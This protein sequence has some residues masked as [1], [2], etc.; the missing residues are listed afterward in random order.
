VSCALDIDQDLSLRTGALEQLKARHAFLLERF[1][2]ERKKVRFMKLCA[3]ET[4]QRLTQC[5]SVTLSRALLLAANLEPDDEILTA[6]EAV[7]AAVGS[8]KRSMARHR[9]EALTGPQKVVELLAMHRAID[10]PPFDGP[11]LETYTDDTLYNR[12]SLAAEDNTLHHCHV[13]PTQFALFCQSRGWPI[14][15]GLSRLA[16]P[17]DSGAKTSGNLDWPWGRYE[18]EMLRHLHAAALKWWIRYDPRE[19]T[20]APTQE[21]VSDWLISERHLSRKKAEAIAAV[22]HTDDPL[23]KGPRR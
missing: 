2:G 6:F 8:E 9:L 5:R 16:R 23:P 4:W 18:T 14:P 15:Q 3:N 22:L 1:L 13:R 7:L 19:P 17:S 10:L 12:G 20:T 11:I 21:T